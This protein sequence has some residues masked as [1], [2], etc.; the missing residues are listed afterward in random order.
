LRRY[1]MSKRYIYA[2]IDPSLTSTGIVAIKAGGDTVFSHDI[3]TAPK[4]APLQ[5]LFD[6]RH[7]VLTLLDGLRLSDYRVLVGIEGYAYGRVNQAH[8]LGELGGVLRVALFEAGYDMVDVAPTAVKKFATGKGNAKKDQ[9]LLAVYKKWGA[10]FQS[11]DVADAYVIAQIV[12]HLHDPNLRL[13]KHEA[14]VIKTLRQGLE[15][16][17]GGA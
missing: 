5:R 8:A 10:E 17:W 14:E 9:I 2:G 11:N 16:D 6:I 15:E 13:M 3:K 1:E 12:K 4:T 7:R